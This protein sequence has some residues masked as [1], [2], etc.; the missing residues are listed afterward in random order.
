MTIL[1][2]SYCP[3]TQ[4]PESAPRLVASSAPLLTPRLLIP[5]EQVSKA[6]DSSHATVNSSQEH[7]HRVRRLEGWH[8]RTMSAGMDDPGIPSSVP[9]REDCSRTLP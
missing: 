6:E 8:Q 5:S 2:L 1:G 7:T 4:S 9:A 3:E